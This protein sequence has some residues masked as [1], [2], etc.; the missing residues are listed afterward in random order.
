MSHDPIP[1]TGEPT[2]EVVTIAE[3]IR[4][5]QTDLADIAKYLPGDTRRN[6]RILDR[7]SE[8]LAEIAGMLRALPGRPQW[9][10]GYALAVEGALRTAVAAGEDP[11]KIAERAL[12]RIESEDITS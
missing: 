1:P 3:S 5:V 2:P 4:S 8:E 11:R 6:A 7:L 12:A 10:R 9:Q